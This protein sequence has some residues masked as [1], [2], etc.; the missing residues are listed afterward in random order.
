VAPVSG[1]GSLARSIRRVGA[2]A[3][4]VL[5]TVAVALVATALVLVYRPGL[6]DRRLLDPGVGRR[7]GRRLRG[8]VARMACGAL[9]WPHVVDVL[10]RANRTVVPSAIGPEMTRIGPGRLRHVQ[11][12]ATIGPPVI[13]VHSLVSA[14]TILDI[15]PEEGL[16]GAL[17]AAGYDVWVLDWADPTPADAHL[18]LADHVRAVRDSGRAVCATRGAPAVHLVGYCFGATLALARAGAW[19]DGSVASL[20]L[21][22][23][24]VDMSAAGGMG[25]VLGHPRLHPALALDGDDL[26][27][28]PLVREAFHLLRPQALRTVWRGLRLSG[29]V[30]VRQRYAAMARWTWEHRDLPGATWFDIVDLQRG[31]SL[32][33]GTLSIDGT[34]TGVTAI[35]APT[36]IVCAEHDHIVPPACSLLLCDVL[37]RPPDVRIVPRGHVGMLVSR[38]RVLAT[39]VVEWLRER[40]V[41]P[42]RRG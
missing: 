20:A 34:A 42:A 6:T 28:G 21:I 27:P 24:V 17:A 5:A 2:F 16:V 4:R 8:R 36:L 29:D 23:P 30:A 19:P 11:G 9:A 1:L 3:A 26:V 35:A 39:H 12:S 33:R 7:L 18:T 14:S 40:S 13:V 38:D 22:A 32:A 15:T 41:K 10:S 25:T 37:P 31:N